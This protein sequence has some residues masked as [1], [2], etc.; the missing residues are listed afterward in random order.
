MQTVQGAVFTAP[1]IVKIIASFLI[2]PKT[3][4]C[5]CVRLRL[6]N[7]AFDRVLMA[8]TRWKVPELINLRFAATPTFK[9]LYTDVFKSLVAVGKV[10]TE[11]RIRALAGFHRAYLREVGVRI[12][13]L[14]GVLMRCIL[15]EIETTVLLTF[16]FKGVGWT[17]IGSWGPS[18]VTLRTKDELAFVRGDA[19]T[20]V[21]DFMWKHTGQGQIVHETEENFTTFKSPQPQAFYRLL[22]KELG[23]C[24]K[25]TRAELVGGIRENI[26]GWFETAAELE[27]P[28]YAAMMLCNWICTR[29]H[30]SCL[31]DEI[32]PW[33]E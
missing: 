25:D 30:T 23:G 1:A 11:D 26:A 21:S 32:R 6:V 7:T 19:R 29:L 18:L 33:Y 4:W 3:P 9:D 5:E 14:F 20:N 22:E 10:D 12:G 2:G 28:G 24:D 8:K 27:T 15:I 13:H 31:Y 16:N 17:R